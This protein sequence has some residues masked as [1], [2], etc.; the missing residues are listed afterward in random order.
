MSQ[1][2][3]NCAGE[4]LILLPE[5]AVLWPR[6]STLIVADTHF[7]KSASFRQF[8]IAAPE[9]TSEDLARLTHLLHQH[10]VERLV[11]LGDF[12]HAPEGRTKSTMD[13]LENWCKEMSGTKILLVSGNHDARAGQPPKNWCIEFHKNAFD[14]PPFTY[15]HQPK[16]KK[17]TYVLCGHIHPAI[18]LSGKFGGG[19]KVPSFIFG[20]DRAILPAF[21]SF[22]GT[23]PHKPEPG[24]QIY[25]VGDGSI[26]SIKASLH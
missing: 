1:L 8:G 22:T 13:L 2:A 25:A 14:D 26:I 7:G 15:C 20:K 4:E 16:C 18:S 6:R 9:S 21:G 5:K 11:I 24:E 12:L 19:L 23:H 10:K 3:I 17:G